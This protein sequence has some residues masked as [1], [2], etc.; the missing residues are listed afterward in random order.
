MRQVFDWCLNPILDKKVR[1]LCGW[2][3][4]IFIKNLTAENADNYVLK[5]ITL[6]NEF[7]ATLLLI[8]KYLQI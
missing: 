3:W 8:I 5:K 2:F 7:D 6:S 1:Y 4:G